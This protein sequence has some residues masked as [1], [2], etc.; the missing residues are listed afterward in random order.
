MCYALTQMRREAKEEGIKEGIKEGRR[1]GIKEGIKEGKR[2]GI[3]EGI[4]E[5]IL[6]RLVTQVCKKR[7]L[8]QTLERI[9]EDLVE[10]ISAIEPIYD[11]AGKY[12]PEYDPE[13]VLR[14][15]AAA[16]V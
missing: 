9:A 12:A 1:E 10:E 2:E 6:R 7:G 5:G 13:A 4:K 3:K 16:A 8:G 15:L 14:E 11:T